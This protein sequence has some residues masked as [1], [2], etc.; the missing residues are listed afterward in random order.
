MLKNILIIIIGGAILYGAF[1]FAMNIQN[2]P[3]VI[4]REEVKILP[5]TSPIPA[6]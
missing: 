5:E 6:E 1:W 2:K 3:V 4:D